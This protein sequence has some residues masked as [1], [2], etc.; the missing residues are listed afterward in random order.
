MLRWVLGCLY[1]RC[2]TLKQNNCQEKDDGFVLTLLWGTS[3]LC[4]EEKQLHTQAYL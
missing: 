2:Q 3:S 1:F 4:F